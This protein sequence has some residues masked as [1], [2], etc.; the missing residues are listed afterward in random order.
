MDLS[1]YRKRIDEID[2][3]MLTLFL[4]RM[5]IAGHIAEYKS[6]NNIPILNKARERE[7]LASVSERAGDMEH[8]AHRLF[9]NIMEISRAYQ[10]SLDTKSS[11]L[12]D[13]IRESRLPADAQ[14]PQTGSIAV[15][16]V[17]GAYAQVAADRLFRRGNVMYFQSFG[18]VFEA[19]ENG[20]CD[21][22]IVPVENSNHG[23]V[24]DVYEL[25]RKHKVYITRT[26]KVHIR[27][28]LLGKP[29]TRLEDVKEIYSHEQ[30]IGQ[31]EAFLKSLG[32]DVKVIPVANTALAAKMVANSNRE[33]VAS[34]SSHEAGEL[35]GLKPIT[36]GIADSDNN[37]TRFAAIR[38]QPAVYPGANRI[39]ICL[40]T[41][42]SPGALYEILSQFSAL[43]LNILKLES[44]PISGSDF[45]F[46][47]YIDFTGSVWDEGT[48]HLLAYLDKICDIFKYLGNYPEIH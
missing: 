4:E 35:Y 10:A 23:S 44:V 2:S 16:G 3:Q 39:S 30:A 12:L 22:G 33:D 7:V 5:D 37:Y 13:T 34:I 21:F 46:L 25:F 17:E 36:T 38:R 6:Q 45:E 24:R 18:A 20:L 28:E 26:T 47:F 27:H 19:V 8:Y 48:L 9:S 11:P 14:F 15:Q 31:C 41:P 40:T 43:D 32:S 29:G 42:H 1:D